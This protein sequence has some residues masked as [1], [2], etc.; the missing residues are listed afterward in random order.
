MGPQDWENNIY[1]NCSSQIMVNGI[2][3]KPA[4]SCG[5]PFSCCAL[6]DMFSDEKSVNYKSVIDTQ[7]GYGVRQTTVSSMHILFFYSLV[8]LRKLTGA[9]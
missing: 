4:E 3:Y 6:G 2:Q 7:C 5:V 1:F 9:T 8:A